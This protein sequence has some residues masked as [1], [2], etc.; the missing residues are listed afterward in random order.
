M[1]LKTQQIFKRE[2]H[3]IFSE[4]I[5]KIDLSSND[6]KRM[7]SIDSIETYAY[8]MRKDLVREKEDIKCKN[9]IK[10][11]KK[12][13]TLMMLRKKIRPKFP[14]I[15]YKILII[16]GS[17]SGKTN[18]LFNQILISNQILI[19]FIYILKIHMKQNINF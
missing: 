6:D 4:E 7:Q 17:G 8:G 9:I 10:R 13:L 2:S 12:C 19:Q 14:D 1:I 18:S 15:P 16:R 11:Y 5:S 3:N